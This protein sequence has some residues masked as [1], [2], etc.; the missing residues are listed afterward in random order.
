MMKTLIIYLSILALEC[1]IAVGI[2]GT[3]LG[4]QQWILI[5]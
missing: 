3:V 5:P 1:I 2:I 4:I